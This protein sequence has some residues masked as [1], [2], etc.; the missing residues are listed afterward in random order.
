MLRGLSSCSVLRVTCPMRD[1]CWKGYKTTC[2]YL[3]RVDQT[4]EMINVKEGRSS[5]RITVVDRDGGVHYNDGG[6]GVGSVA[7]F[8]RMNNTND[9]EQRSFPRSSHM[10]KVMNALFCCR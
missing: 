4:P 9:N 2:F 1:R 10:N 6:D 8:G 7:T 5:G 3:F